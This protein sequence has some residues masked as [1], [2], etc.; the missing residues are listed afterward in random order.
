MDL[1]RRE[2]PVRCS[3]HSAV[4]CGRKIDRVLKIP[5]GNR[6]TQY[7]YQLKKWKLKK[8]IPSAKKSAMCDIYQSRAAQGR[9]TIV[10]YKGKD[11]DVRKLRRQAKTAMR[12]ELVSGP[13]SGNVSGQPRAASGGALRFD[14]KM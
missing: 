1:T 11:V 8:Y 2:C 14:S 13:G 10:K 6:E 3:Q 9:S 12:R 4:S 5:C 7:K